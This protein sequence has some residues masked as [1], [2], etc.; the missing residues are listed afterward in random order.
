MPLG[1]SSASDK[2]A[3]L[4]VWSPFRSARKSTWNVGSY[5]S[6]PEP[7]VVVELDDDDDSPSFGKPKENDRA[8]GCDTRCE[9][10][11]RAT[12]LSIKFANIL[13]SACSVQSGDEVLFRNMVG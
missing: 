11:S 5:C 2:P 4:A 9:L 10:L 3:R 13:R 1:L 12:R 6:S 7:A 8:Y